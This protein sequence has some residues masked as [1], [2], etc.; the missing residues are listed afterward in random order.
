M[1]PAVARHLIYPLQE[2]LVRRPTFPYLRELERRQW[3]TRAEVEQGQLDTLRALLRTAQRHSPWHARRLADVGLDPAQRR[4]LTFDDL[5]SLPTMDKEDARQHRDEIAW[6][7][8]PGG[9]QLYNTGGSS[10]QPLVFYFGRRR[11]ASDAAGR[12]R[13]RRW[14][15]VDVGEREV[16][17][18]GAPVELAKTDH[19]KTARD[20]LINQLVLNA[21]EMSPAV[22]DRYIEAIQRFRPRCLYGYA[23]SVALLAARAEQQGA[24]LKLPSLRVVCTT[25][26]P[27][28]AHQRELIGRVFGVP[29][30]NEYG[31]RDVGF[32][33]HETRAGQVLLMSES[34]ILEVLD[35]AGQPVPVGQPGEAVMT[36][37]CSD[38][39][40][41]IRYRTGDIVT[42]SPAP[43]REGRGLHVL[44]EV[45]GRSTDFV[46]RP[47][48]TVMHALALI[49]VLRATD[50][51]GEFKVRQPGPELLDVRVVPTAAWTEAVERQLAAGLAARMGAGVEIQIHREQQIPPDPSGKFRYVVSDVPL[52]DNL[53]ARQVA[54]P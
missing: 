44:Q 2:R 34:I 43:C 46:V 10:G 8:A 30:A 45:Q 40:P 47:D 26:E 52:P 38:A 32:T 17:L 53:G 35:P 33:A 3:W 7:G 41:F 13:A 42:L 31:S 51:V 21:F 49:Y 11:Q 24:D 5:R 28:Y 12:I 14:W 22:M 25:G 1:I 18:W 29:V 20:R 54:S 50:G 37:L 16:Y 9:A 48:G 36:G 23:S 27:L 19:I 39:Q 15:G 6:P 4:E